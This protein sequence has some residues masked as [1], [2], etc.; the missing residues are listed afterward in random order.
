[1]IIYIQQFVLQFN[2]NVAYF[3]LVSCTILH[4]DISGGCVISQYSFSNLTCSS[5]LCLS[6]SGSISN[7]GLRVHLDLVVIIS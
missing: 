6:R 3:V 4:L 7:V 5:T 1:V 2:L